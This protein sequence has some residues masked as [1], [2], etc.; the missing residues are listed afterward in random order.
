LNLP[1]IKE[2]FASDTQI[3]SLAA[4]SDLITLRLLDVSE[5]DL[6]SLLGM[7]SLSILNLS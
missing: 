2:I 5:N 4:F 1:A 6:S 7:P 3:I